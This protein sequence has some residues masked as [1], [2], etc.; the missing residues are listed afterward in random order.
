MLVLSE[1]ASILQYLDL[2]L[3]LLVNSP[4]D[5][6]QIYA[7]FGQKFMK[8]FHSGVICPKT[9]NLEGVKEAPHSEQATGQGMHYR[10][11][12]WYSRV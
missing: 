7:D 6:R 4:S 9:P 3:L 2:T 11:M 1:L 8:R 12:V 5:F 10:E